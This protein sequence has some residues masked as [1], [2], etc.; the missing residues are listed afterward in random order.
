MSPFRRDGRDGARHGGLRIEAAWALSDPGNREVLLLLQPRPKD[1][2]PDVAPAAAQVV[3]PLKSRHQEPQDP[4]AAG[5]RGQSPAISSRC[6]TS[7]GSW[8][9]AFPQSLSSK[10]I[11][12]L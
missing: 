5:A 2:D 3:E 12:V 4:P 6:F 9:F 10:S 1:A 8:G 7:G 11:S